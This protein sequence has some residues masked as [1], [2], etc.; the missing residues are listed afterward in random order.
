MPKAPKMRGKYEKHEEINYL[1]TVFTWFARYI[2]DTEEKP[3]RF[4][5]DERSVDI[6]VKSIGHASN[7]DE[8][9]EVA[10]AQARQRPYEAAR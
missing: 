8:L 4:V 5:L 9:M 3:A 1:G 2:K 7:Y 6:D 10:K